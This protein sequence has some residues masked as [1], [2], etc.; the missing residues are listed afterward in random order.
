MSTHIRFEGSLK[1]IS[2]ILPSSSSLHCPSNKRYF[3]DY[4]NIERPATQRQHSK[5][6]NGLGKRG[7]SSADLLSRVTA[8]SVSNNM[9][10]RMLLQ[11]NKCHKD[12]CG[13]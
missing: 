6:F 13:S 1:T 2:L 4:T 10:S 8:S 12:D 11:L 9:T 5:S 3:T 7:P